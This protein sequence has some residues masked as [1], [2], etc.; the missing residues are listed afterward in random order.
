MEGLE[1]KNE[2]AQALDVVASED[3]SDNLKK[4]ETKMDVDDLHHYEQF[5]M[6]EVVIPLPGGAEMRFNPLPVYSDLV[7]CGALLCK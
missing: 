5:N 6:R 7:L 1:V 4:D 2:E 3:D